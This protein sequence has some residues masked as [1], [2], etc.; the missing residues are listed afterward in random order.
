MNLNHKAAV[1]QIGHNL[2]IREERDGSFT[3]PDLSKT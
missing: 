3:I 1:P 2:E